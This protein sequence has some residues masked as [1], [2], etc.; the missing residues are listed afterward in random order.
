M[1][2]IFGAHNLSKVYET[3][4][5]T[6]SPKKITIHDDWN[7]HTTQYDGDISLLEFEKGNIHF[8]DYVQPICLWSSE[9]EPT[10]RV[11]VVVGWGRSEARYEPFQ[12]IPKLINVRIHTR[13]ECFLGAK[14]LVDLSSFRTFCAGLRNGSGV[15]DGDSGG[16]LFV[17][18]N[19]VYYLK[20]IVSSSLVKNSECDVSNNAVYTNVLKFTDWIDKIRKSVLTSHVPEKI[21]TSNKVDSSTAWSRPTVTSSRIVYPGEE[22]INFQSANKNQQFTNVRLE[23]NLC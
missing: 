16:G 2:A 1:L 11:G 14:S 21:E 10:E 13:E 23:G 5:F 4:R 18:V 3:R 20:G 17:R 19:G 6:D 9:I 8:N 12:P 15:C 22:T 7:P